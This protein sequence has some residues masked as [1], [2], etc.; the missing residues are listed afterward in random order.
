MTKHKK[1]IL[2]IPGAAERSF[3]VDA[4]RVVDPNTGLVTAW[5]YPMNCAYSDEIA[6]LTHCGKYARVKKENDGQA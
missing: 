5:A 4:V 6:R 3:R 1:T 2:H